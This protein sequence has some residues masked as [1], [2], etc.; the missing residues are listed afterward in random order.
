LVV[1]RGERQKLFIG[2]QGLFKIAQLVETDSDEVE[3]DRCSALVIS[4]LLSFQDP[5]ILRRSSGE[6]VKLKECRPEV[7]VSEVGH[8]VLETPPQNL[9]QEWDRFLKTSQS[10]H[11]RCDADLVTRL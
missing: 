10:N 3:R 8:F 5:E 9:T 11:G 2:L 7:G 1:G 6:V 4:H